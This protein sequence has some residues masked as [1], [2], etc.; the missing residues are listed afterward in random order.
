[1]HIPTWSVL[2]GHLHKIRDFIV[3]VL[4]QQNLLQTERSKPVGWT[5]DRQKRIRADSNE[6]G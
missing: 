5:G 1:M 6:T 2:N 4:K 3:F